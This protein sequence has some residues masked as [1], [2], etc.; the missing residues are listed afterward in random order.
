MD[1]ENVATSAEAN[2]GDFD[3]TAV[4]DLLRTRGRLLIK[5][6]YGDWGR[7][8]RYRRAMLENGIDLFQ[9]YSV[10]SQQKNRADVRL[11]IDA[12]ETVFTRPS[13][14]LYVIVSGDSDFTELIHKLR[15][16]G[17]YTI[18]I[19]LRAATSDL[20]RR[21]C[22]EFIFYETLV[23]EEAVDISDELRLPDPREL[24]RRALSAAEQKGELPIYAGR[25]KQLM[26]N[27][28]SSFSEANYGYQQFRAFLEAYPDLVVV[29]EQGL[30][31]F[32]SIRKPAPPITPPPLAK[33]AVEPAAPPRSAGSAGAAARAPVAALPSPTTSSVA[34]PQG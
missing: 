31:L 25:L 6:A 33:P 8:H 29:E 22:D 2:F 27:L 24:L 13:I 11:A 18:G 28:D 9:L 23:T 17:K 12:L 30:Q 14:D 19:G 20:L 34:R 5:R 10:G 32:V 3:V 21:A 16:Y 1:F 4:M 7:F 15:D 26:L